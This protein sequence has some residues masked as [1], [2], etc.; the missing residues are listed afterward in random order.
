MQYLGTV[1]NVG[2]LLDI[3]KKQSI[4]SGLNFK[5]LDYGSDY[6]AEVWYNEDTAEI[7][8]I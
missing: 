5:D 3:L 1:R 2:E 6:S 7:C 8:F 4:V